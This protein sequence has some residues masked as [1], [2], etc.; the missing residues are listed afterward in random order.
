MATGA[1]GGAANGAAKRVRAAPKWVR[2][3]AHANTATGAFGGAPYGATKC[4]RRGVCRNACSRRMRA[5][6]LGPSVELPMGARTCEGSVEML[7]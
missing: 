6:T 1:F 4:V 3:W 2:R 7:A 5:Q